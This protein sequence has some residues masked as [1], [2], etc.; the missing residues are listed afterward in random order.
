MKL[1]GPF[2]KAAASNWHDVGRAFVKLSLDVILNQMKRKKGLDPNKW[3]SEIEKIIGLENVFVELHEAQHRLSFIIDRSPTKKFNVT[4]L[5]LLILLTEQAE[6]DKH[7]GFWVAFEELNKKLEDCLFDQLPLEEVR[8]TLHALASLSPQSQQRIIEKVY[9]KTRKDVESQVFSELCSVTADNWRFAWLLTMKA[10]TSVS[11]DSLGVL[12][13]DLR[14]L[15]SM[16]ANTWSGDK[17]VEYLSEHR[18][19]G[20]VATLLLEIEENPHKFVEALTPCAWI[21]GLPNGFMIKCEDTNRQK[22]FLESMRQQLGQL[23]LNPELIRSLNCP[24]N[25]QL[26]AQRSTCCGFGHYLQGIWDAIPNEERSR[27]KPP[28]TVCLK[29]ALV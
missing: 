17:W 24:F 15:N 1:E 21:Y 6:T 8:A 5:D 20:R 16:H 25:V 27:L 3:M 7:D 9:P 23:I 28:S 2:E 26:N 19:V 22:L 18:E 12:E 13:W 10:E 11:Y 29:D 4:T 14:R